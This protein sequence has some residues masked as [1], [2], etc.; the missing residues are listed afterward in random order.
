[1]GAIKIWTPVEGILFIVINVSTPSQG[2]TTT[3]QENKLFFVL[4]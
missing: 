2:G 3:I 4:L 1:M